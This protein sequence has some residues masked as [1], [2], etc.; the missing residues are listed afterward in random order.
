MIDAAHK[1]GFD[2]ICATLI[3]TGKDDRKTFEPVWA[4]NWD[5]R[6]T[7]LNPKT[8]DDKWKEQVEAIG[9]DLWTWIC[10]ALAP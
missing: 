1:G 10:C 5:E 4:M 3:M 8:T 2:A 7:L 6:W 9:R